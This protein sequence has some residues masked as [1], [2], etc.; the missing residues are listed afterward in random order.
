MQVE[1]QHHEQ[2]NSI[3]HSPYYGC[4]VRVVSKAR[5]VYE[6]V[7]DGISTDKDRIILKNV[8]VNA[9]APPSRVLGNDIAHV[10]R[11][12]TSD[13]LN[14]VMI[15]HLTNDIRIYEQVCLTVSDIEELRLIE[16][17]STFHESKAKLRAID[18]CLVDIRLSPS[19]EH[20]TRSHP[21][22]QQVRA[23]IARQKRGESFGSDGGSALVT[24]SSNESSS[25]FSFHSREKFT[26]DES[27]DESMDEYM[28]QFRQLTIRNAPA[29]PPTLLA[30]K[31]LPRKIERPLATATMA[32]Q[33]APRAVYVDN[34]EPMGNASRLNQH[35]S[36]KSLMVN[37]NRQPSPIR[38]TITS[39]L[40]PNAV[41]FYVQ[42][43][44]ASPMHNP[45]FT[46][47]ERTRFRPRLQPVLSPDRSQSLPYGMNQ[48]RTPTAQPPHQRFVPPRQ[49]AIKQNFIPPARTHPTSIST[50]M[51]MARYR[52][53]SASSLGK[54]SYIQPGSRHKPSS[55]S[56]GHG[57]MTATP[58]SPSHLPL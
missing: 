51:P 30:K 56:T 36:R 20:E 57:R 22:Q 32:N 13:A 53:H 10:N 1:E 31:V 5:V 41:P 17:P 47:Y 46:F 42:Q 2:C 34:R 44:R 26:A 49:M 7:L 55:N 52:I 40:N 39:K 15:D 18:P 6:G 11:T 50:S 35:A 4:T 14:A 16:L 38:V 12:S 48:A 9:N 33:Q 23:P 54:Q 58:P 21:K 3:T 29:K 25:S 27:N 19:D 37:Q 8:R 24:S 28:E 43:R 45:S